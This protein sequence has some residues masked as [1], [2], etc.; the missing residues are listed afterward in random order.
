MSSRLIPPKVGAIALTAAMTSS[1]VGASSS[2]SNTSM[3]ANLNRFDLPSITGLPASGPMFSEAQHSGHSRPQ[4]PDCPSRCSPYT[5]SGFFAI[6]RHGS[7]TPG[8]YARERSRCVSKGWSARPRAS[9]DGRVR[10]PGEG[11][12]SF[13]A[14][15]AST[16]RRP[17]PR[18]S[19]RRMVATSRRAWGSYP[20]PTTPATAQDSL[21]TTATLGEPLPHRRAMRRVGGSRKPSSVPCGP[22]T[23]PRWCSFI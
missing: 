22:V 10:D 19:L 9:L 12:P 23:L 20:A 15:L 1:A 11:G 16:G 8:E 3:S 5:A 13:S 2:M 6:R 7:A 4:R 18:P 14:F 17:T 21:R